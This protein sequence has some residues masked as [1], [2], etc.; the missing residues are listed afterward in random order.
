MSTIL[1]V[2]LAI[3]VLGICIFIHELGHYLAARACGLAVL[4][5]A[6]GMGPKIIGWRKNDIDYSIRAFPIGGFCSF[7]GESPD[8]E[9]SDPRNINLQPAWK[10]LIM[11]AAGPFM[12][13]VLALV[14]AVVLMAAVGEYVMVNRIDTVTD[15]SPA[16]TAGLLPGDRIKAG[17]NDYNDVT[18]APFV[19]MIKPATPTGEP[20]YTKITTSGKTLKDVTLT[21]ERGGSTFDAVVAKQY[22]AA[23]GR[24][25]MG[26]TF[27]VENV[28]IGFFKAVGSSFAYCAELF[29]TMIKTLGQMFTQKDVLDQVAGPVG[30]VSVMTQYAQQSFAQSFNEGMTMVLNLAVIISMN[31]GLMNFLPLPALDGGRAV[32]LLVETVTGKHL[33]RKHEAI[34]HFVGLIL[35]LGLIVL[36][37][38]RDILRLFGV[39]L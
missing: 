32:L 35:L 6:V 3:L 28:R 38:G 26:V 12:N 8:D 7:A 30:T 37:T 39:N 18:S 15:G 14:L 1:Y 16:A 21:I 4:E 24:Y 23:S 17:D 36:L 27:G 11:T 9:E 20:K 13:F 34:V 10:R 25:L 31:L 2:L 33:S 19:L 22:D 5:F 29:K